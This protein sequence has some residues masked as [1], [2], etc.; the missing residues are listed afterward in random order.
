MQ[1]TFPAIV[2]REIADLT[3]QFGAP[4]VQS[5]AVGTRA[6]W[7]RQMKNRA[8]EVCM[9]IRRMNGHLLVSTKTFYPDN[10]ARLMTGG[11]EPGERVLD[12][13]LRE[14]YEETGLQVAVQRLLALVAYRPVD[15]RPEADRAPRFFTF[16]FLL[17]ETGGTLG[18][19][20]PN[21][22]IAAYREIAPEE[23]PRVADHLD[24]LPATYDVTLADN[25]RAWGEFRA[26]I[27]RVVWDAWR[28]GQF[29]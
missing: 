3:A 13:L 17:D 28:A 6:F 25:W 10:V 23:L 26:V 21:E 5:I 19:T 16:A 2:Q 20:D 18:A 22:R 7:D 24:Q 11:V 9:V 12:A 1:T 14:V 4:S 8:S 27:H 29:A 15:E